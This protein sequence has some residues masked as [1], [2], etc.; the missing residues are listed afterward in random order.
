MTQ[1]WRLVAGSPKSPP[2]LGRLSINSLCRLIVHG[3]GVKSGG[4]ESSFDKWAL[5]KL[6]ASRISSEA[7]RSKDQCHWLDQ[8]VWP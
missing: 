7:P 3:E 8:V 6:I 1:M 2:G 4:C 5:N